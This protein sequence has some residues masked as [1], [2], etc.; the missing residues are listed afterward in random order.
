MPEQRGI[1]LLV[2]DEPAVLRALVRQLAGCPFELVTCSTAQEAVQRVAHGG[3]HVVV[4]DIGMPGLSGIQLLRAARRYDADL[5]VVLLTGHSDREDA[6][7]TDGAFEILVKPVERD[8]LRGAIERALRCYWL[9][10]MK[11]NVRKVIVEEP[12]E[13]SAVFTSL[14]AGFERALGRLWVA[15]QPIVRASDRSVLGHEALLRTDE[16]SLPGPGHILEAA[17]KLDQLDRLGRIVRSLALE[18]LETASGRDLLFLNLHPRDLRD[19]LLWDPASP[20]SRV[21]DRVVLEITERA[22]L[23][24]IEEVRARIARLRELGYRIALDDLGAGY[25]GFKSLALLE[26]DIVK[27]DMTLVR[28]IEASPF[29]RR[30]VGSML[31]LCR[32]MGLAIVAEG[33][34]TFAER[35]TLLELGCDLFQGHLFGRPE[36]TF[37]E[38]CWDV[39]PVETFP[40]SGTHRIDSRRGRDLVDAGD[41]AD[42]IEVSA[43]SGE[44]LV[45][46]S[47]LEELSDG[48]VVADARGR[49]VFSNAAAEAALG[50]AAPAEPVRE[51][52]ERRGLWLPDG[53]TPFPPADSPLVR[54]LAGQATDVEMCVRNAIVPQGMHVRVTA[55]PILDAQGSVRGACAVFRDVTAFRRAEQVALRVQAEL[56]GS[57]RRRAE[58]SAF[59]VHDLK[60]PLSAILGSVSSIMEGTTSPAEQRECLRD[61]RDSALAMHRMVLDMLDL[62]MAEDGALIADRQPFEIA[63]LLEE[64]R[65]AMGPR[66]AQRGQRIEISA[67]EP[68]TIVRGD[69]DL[70]RRVLQNLVD[71]CIKYGPSGG[72]IRLDARLAGSASLL[73]RV[74][75]EGPGVPVALRQRIFEKYAQ[76]EPRAGVR[77]RDSRGLGLRFCQVAVEAHGG[78]VWVEDNQ[79]KGACFSI[80]LPIHAPARTDETSER[81]A[82]AGGASR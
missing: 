55:R 33:V 30:L 63:G 7:A 79:P 59:L 69:R 82:A 15:F 10:K 34:E 41:A 1:V 17:E 37:S 32:D 16:P 29:K 35:D 80:E 66:A 12:A 75:D 18:S 58:L 38:P 42:L 4:S 62:H 73:L 57:Q 50:V 51:W 48:V 54:A 68:G 8:A 78:R 26:P 47:I 67:V 23:G 14:R 11:R 40:A 74:R 45:P 70:L 72:T 36:R 24:D 2:D 27:L 3:V 44:L 25:A 65:A 43:K 5:P 81:R 53:A 46:L 19:P 64:V 71:N 28:G 61:I 6:P 9:K 31:G 76:G 56:D 20:L 49:I 22:S 39:L 52:H 13:T 21:A 60:S 77:H